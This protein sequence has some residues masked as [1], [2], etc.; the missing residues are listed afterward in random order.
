MIRRFLTLIDYARLRVK[1]RYDITTKNLRRGEWEIEEL[2]HIVKLHRLDLPSTGHAS[3]Y[4]AM[5]AAAAYD[6][7]NGGK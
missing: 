6:K 5:R 3:E 4:D 2:D 1:W 7:L